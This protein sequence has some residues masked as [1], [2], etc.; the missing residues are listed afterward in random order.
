MSHSTWIRSSTDSAIPDCELYA[1]A[2]DPTGSLPCVE[3]ETFDVLLRRVAAFGLH[4]D[5]DL[6]VDLGDDEWSGFLQLT[7]AHRLSGLLNEAVL[8]GSLSLEDERRMDVGDLHLEVAARVLLLETTLLSVVELLDASGVPFRV[9]KGPAAA[10]RYSDPMWRPYVDIDLL[11]PGDRF[12]DAARILDRTGYRRRNAGLGADFDR[13]FGKGATFH[14]ETTGVN[15]DLHRTLVA[16]PYGFLIDPGDLFAGS[17]RIDMAGV[18]LPALDLEAQFIHSC[19]STVLSDV[20]PKLITVRDVVQH[21]RVG[22]LDPPTVDDLC[23]RWRIGDVVSAAV[24][25]AEETL[26]VRKEQGSTIAPRAPHRAERIAT[27]AY[28]GDRRRWRRQALTAGVF[29]PGWTDRLS[30]FRSVIRARGLDQLLSQWVAEHDSRAAGRNAAT[31]FLE[32]PHVPAER[33]TSNQRHL[34][35]VRRLLVSHHRSIRPRGEQGLETVDIEYFPT[36]R[37]IAHRLQFESDL[38]SVVGHPVEPVRKLRTER[39]TVDDLRWQDVG[40]RCPADRPRRPVV[41]RHH[42]GCCAGDL[43]ESTIRRGVADLYTEPKAGRRFDFG[44]GTRDAGISARCRVSS[45]ADAGSRPRRASQGEVQLGE[46]IVSDPRGRQPVSQCVEVRSLGSSSAPRLRQQRPDHEAAERRQQR[47]A[48]LTLP[49]IRLPGGSHPSAA[50][51][52][53]QQA[54]A[55]HQR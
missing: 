46:A 16:G 2:P 43:E 38:V 12:A 24:D 19:I 21:L 15:I 23:E 13:R 50:G 51:G 33:N 20:R 32:P 25:L 49:R 3:S 29:V 39:P 41:R 40:H 45:R 27:W 42:S 53:A 26:D 10:A 4:D 37:V 22:V 31:S 48:G 17:A 5:L 47:L 14:H 9:L 18:S 54:R 1:L 36:R 8:T 30:Y 28:A 11:V 44:L 35:V 7:R 34:V 55:G 6:A 52:S